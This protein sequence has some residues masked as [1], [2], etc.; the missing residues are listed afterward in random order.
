V[1]H[2]R[3]VAH[4]DVRTWLRQQLIVHAC[5]DRRVRLF[6]RVTESQIVRYYRDHQQ[7]IGV[8]LDAAIHDQIRRLLTERQVNSRLTGLLEQRG[9]KGNLEFPR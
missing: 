7:A 4:P 3:G 6:V 1:V 2:E 8:P 5:I 9:K